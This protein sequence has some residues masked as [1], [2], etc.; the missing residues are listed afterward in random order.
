MPKQ[1]LRGRERTKKHHNSPRRNN[2]LSTTQSIRS[3]EILKFEQS[4]VPSAANGGLGKVALCVCARTSQSSCSKSALPANPS[5]SSTANH[6]GVSHLL[7]QFPLQT[8][9]RR[10]CLTAFM[11]IVLGAYGTVLLLFDEMGGGSCAALSR[12]WP[13][14]SL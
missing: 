6:A 4:T 13:R 11:A 5:F 7:T 8:C 3:E 9:R 14:A 2:S 1:I 10:P 12:A